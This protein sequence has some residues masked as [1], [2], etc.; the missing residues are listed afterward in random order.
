MLSF[1]ALDWQPIVGR[2]PGL[3]N[4]ARIGRVTRHLSP[5]TRKLAR[6][7]MTAANKSCMPAQH[8]AADP[9]LPVADLMDAHS[10]TQD[11]SCRRSLD[12]TFSDHTFPTGLGPTATKRPKLHLATRALHFPANRVRNSRKQPSADSK[13][14]FEAVAT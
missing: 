3:R 9:P 1:Q 13:T 12:L 14:S 8:S 11:P 6:F 4:E 7:V 5:G 2:L 10:A